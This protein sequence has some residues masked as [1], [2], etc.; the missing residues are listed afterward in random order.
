MNL[1]MG[2]AAL[3]CVI[4]GG[5]QLLT[6][7]K[8]KKGFACLA[9][10]LFLIVSEL[11][12]GYWM[13]FF[14]GEIPHF[15]IGLY[16]GW[17]TKGIWGLVTLGEVPGIRGDHSTTLMINGILT[18][19][20]LL[21]FLCLYIWNVA[22]ACREKPPVPAVPSFRNR[23]ETKSFP[24]LVF[25]PVAVLLVFVVL[26][27]IVFSVLTA[28]TNYDASHLPP[29]N[30]VD[31]VGFDN[32]AK[33]FSVPIWSQTFLAVLGWTV[34]W[35]LSATLST[36]FV[37][38]YH[39]L[40]LNSPHV[41]RKGFFRTIFILPWAIPGMISLL[42]FRNLLNGQFG[43]IN[44]LLLDLG[45]IQTRI[46]FLTDPVLAKITVLVVNLWLGFPAF[47]VMLQGVMANQSTELYEAAAIDGANRFQIFRR[48]KLPLLT[49]ATA[50]LII[51]NL[52]NNFNAFGSIYFLT[53]GGPVNSSM[54][55][56]GDTDILISW[57]YKLTLSQQLYSMAAVMNILIFL[58]IGGVSI[59]NFRRTSAFKEM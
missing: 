13:N 7:H 11:F 26:M 4:W 48:I 27:P 51:M 2:H 42:V 30:L 10:Q 23:Q 9:A 53:D 24:Y 57:I 41:K 22:D 28:F 14:A 17:I 16:G 3:S 45:L 25:L 44:Q 32:V 50:P 8:R 40:L 31:W 46:P 34:V 52:A 18:I 15:Q 37:G 5:G 56:A 21:P 36:Y 1:R 59:W 49:R 38:L 35:A 43:P 19:L 20:A 55:F 47:M 29:A 39:A 58:F 33:L 54:Q 6:P 12:S